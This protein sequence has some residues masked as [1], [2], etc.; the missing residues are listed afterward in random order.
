M[1]SICC[2][3]G[4]EPN[5]AEYNGFEPLWWAFSSW[6]RTAMILRWNPGELLSISSGRMTRVESSVHLQLYAW[7]RC[8]IIRI[9]QKS[10]KIIFLSSLHE[11]EPAVVVKVGETF[12]NFCPCALLGRADFGY[13]VAVLSMSACSLRGWISSSSISFRS[14]CTETL[15]TG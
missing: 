9:C 5:S 10:N 14:S 1:R 13:L 12:Y 15:L 6:W 3:V 11:E 8:Q 2:Y 7:L 4:S